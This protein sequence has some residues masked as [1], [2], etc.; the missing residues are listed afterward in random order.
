M[1]YPRINFN[2]NITHS[3][4]NGSVILAFVISSKLFLYNFFSWHIQN[5]STFRLYQL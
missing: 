2:I 5:F 4:T 3:E 1:T